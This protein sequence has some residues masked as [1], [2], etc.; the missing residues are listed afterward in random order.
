MSAHDL[1][2]QAPKSLT[3]QLILRVL[4]LS[5]IGAFGLGGAVILSWQV[6]ML[7]VQN[8]M[9]EASVTA[10]RTFDLFFLNLQ[11]SLLATGNILSTHEDADVAL[12]QLQ[13]HSRSI[14]DVLLVDLEGQ[15]LGQRNAVGRSKWT[16]IEREQWLMEPPSFGEVYVT[17]VNFEE[18][19]PF[20]SEGPF[21]DMAVTVTDDIG[22]S[23]GLLLI[24]VD[25]TALWKTT[26]DLKVGETGYT[27]IVDE[28]GHL[29]A[30]RNRRLLEEG[31]NLVSLVDRTPEAI[32]ETGLDS[33]LNPNQQRVFA[34]AR[35]MNIVPWF[36]IVEHPVDEALR[37]FLEPTVILS[38]ILIL[39][40][41]LFY[42]IIR[43]TG[44]RII[45]PLRSM[46]Q[47]V[48]QVREGHLES[49]I[50]ATYNDE[51]GQLAYSFNRMSD[52]L[53][54]L[55]TSLEDQVSARTQRL[56]IIA[57]ISNQLTVILDLEILMD[58]VVNQ[59]KD[60][61][62]Y[63]HAH[64]Y[65]LDNNRQNLIVSAGTGVAGA[66][67]KA[68]KHTI[69]LDARTSLVAQAARTGRIVRVDNVRQATDW[70]PN[71]LL[72]DTYA[73]MAVPILLD[74][75][76]VGVL[77]VQEDK[78]AGLDEGDENLLR[79]LASQVAIAIRNA[80]LFARVEQSLA[81]AQ[82]LQARYVERIWD[83]HKIGTQTGRYHYIR[84]DNEVLEANGLD[85]ESSEDMKTPVML[86][87]REIGYLQ[88]HAGSGQQNWTNDE[89]AIIEAVVEQLAQAAENIRLFDETRER[90]DYERL[91]SEITQK[92]RQSP[93]LDVLAM[94]ASEAISAVLGVSGGVVYL[95]DSPDR[96][97]PFP[98]PS[99]KKTLSSFADIPN[100]A[101][102]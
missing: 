58:E 79:S 38:V 90:A 67:L 56:E 55:I 100:Q 42:S 81:E 6:T 1:I 33:Y 101:E 27:Y 21:V 57:V 25:L 54:A 24:R 35:P 31:Q 49:K 59:V 68:R 73:E 94:T 64:I 51:L 5:L 20:A 61:F 17:P 29:V 65:L 9:N 63:Y 18:Q 75:L 82:S 14:L 16:E 80:Q 13:T 96:Q 95:G 84:A 48:A 50:E 36:A 47:A 60:Q 74:E 53:Q 28:R 15:I 26:L 19:V 12:L 85:R 102:T 77:D 7:Q 39:V 11:S 71:A 98:H 69:P 76:V 3:R 46:R 52:Q 66:T 99:T 78:I 41:L 8:Q 87:D 97:Q 83:K 4:L 72:P 86:R 92:I 88:I 45:S 43:F 62:N 93:N 34:S 44:N 30:Y 22:L 91:V 32:V 23:A 70:L 2:S 40:G 89:L 37:P 10:A